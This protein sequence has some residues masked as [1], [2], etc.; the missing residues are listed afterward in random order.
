M[1]DKEDFFKIAYSLKNTDETRE[2]YDRW[3]NVYDLDLKDGDYQQPARCAAALKTQLSQPDALVLDVGCGTGLSGLALNQAGYTRIDGCDLSQGMLDRAAKLEIY[4]RLF[5]CDLNQPPLDVIDE[6]YD[7][8]T[9][10]GVFS[11]CHIMPEAVDELLRVI[12]PGGTII[13]GLNDHYYDE[14]MLT[15]KLEALEKQDLLKIMKREHGEHIPQ[16]DLKGW[17]L[18]I[19]KAG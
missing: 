10:V 8:L 3:A 19:S 14:G 12:R 9:A 17:V 6:T 1:S 5:A 2:M 16:N 13:I 11:F 15:E 4:N 7:A 18:T